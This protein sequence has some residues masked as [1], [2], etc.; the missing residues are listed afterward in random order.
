MITILAIV[1]ASVLFFFGFYLIV[2]LVT[3]KNPFR[4]R[5][6]KPDRTDWATVIVMT[7]LFL[8]QVA[9]IVYWEATGHDALQ[10][11]G[12]YTFCVAVVVQMVLYTGNYGLLIYGT[13]KYNKAQQ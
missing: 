10:S 7:V 2:A 11:N 4:D 13:R 8:I 1:G 3:W 9:L 6:D 5:P 12:Y